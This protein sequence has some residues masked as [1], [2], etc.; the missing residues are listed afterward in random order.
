MANE[1]NELQSMRKISVTA[2]LLA[3]LFFFYPAHAAQLTDANPGSNPPGPSAMSS[4]DDVTPRRRVCDT[5][6]PSAALC[7]FLAAV[8]AHRRGPVSRTRRVRV[9][10]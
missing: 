9:R 4:G 1:W 6:T 10:V 2:L 7:H 5:H 3:V 8:S